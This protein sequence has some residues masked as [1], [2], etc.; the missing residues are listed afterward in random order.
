[1]TEGGSSSRPASERP[2]AIRLYSLLSLM[3]LLWAVNFVIARVALQEF[4]SLLAASL[5][6]CFAAL[7]LVGVYF[8][9]SRKAGLA[10]WER[11]DLPMLVLLGILGVTLNQVLFL[12]GLVR[13]N[14]AHAAVMIGLTPLMVLLL[15]AFTGLEALS[16]KKILGIGV[17]LCGIAVL[18]SSRTSSGTP[19]TMLGDLLI[20][21]AALAFALFVVLGKR[22]TARH[23]GLTVNTLAYVSGGVFLLPVI[24]W[25]FSW[26]DFGQVSWKAWSAVVYMS[27]FPS[28]ICYLIF[29]WALTH[30]PASRVSNF[31]YL[32]PLL[33]TVLGVTLLGDPVSST[34]VAG[35]SLVLTGVFLT[36]RG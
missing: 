5:R 31:G 1:M 34:L 28:A 20:L 27:V 17:A 35:G 18:Q 10:K 29:Y 30:I 2:S 16:L 32:Q 7:F 21:G 13:T 23:G 3:V 9:Q 25:H 36:E 11:G 19:A 4:P 33:A 26:F 12:M 6:A 8:W 22:I 24:F 15:G 14:T